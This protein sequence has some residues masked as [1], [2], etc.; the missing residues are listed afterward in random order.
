MYR[1]TTK[2][3]F[4]DEQSNLF[5]CCRQITIEAVKYPNSTLEYGRVVARDS[6]RK[7]A[8]FG[9]LSRYGTTE[10]SCS[11]PA[12]QEMTPRLMRTLP[13]ID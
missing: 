10:R 12:T 9:S 5:S 11:Q 13:T 2:V 4:Y 3:L 7:P 6:R 1:N 8:F